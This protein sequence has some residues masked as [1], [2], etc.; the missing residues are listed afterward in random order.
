MLVEKLFS[1]IKSI[2]I[3]ATAAKAFQYLY[4]RIKFNFTPLKLKLKKKFVRGDLIVAHG[5]HKFIYYDNGDISERLYHSFWKKYYEEELNKVQNYIRKGDTVIDVGG[6][7]GFYTLLLSELVGV[8]GKVFTFE[9]FSENFKK[10]NRTISINNLNNVD[11]FNVGLGEEERKAILY[12]DSHQTGM[13]T[14]VYKISS[15]AITEEIKLT[16]LDKFFEKIKKKISFIKIDTEGYEPQVLLGGKRIL[17]KDK[18]VI[19]IELGG[20]YFES[21]LFALKILKELNY[22]CDAFNINLKEIPAGTNFICKPNN[23]IE[24]NKHPV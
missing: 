9:P 21:S 7:L 23:L 20:E 17:L 14:I 8:N 4:N 19:C 3:Q 1:N 6:N 16:T 10:L 24:R 13:S 5:K 12:Y 2:G 18:P 11:S 22:D 15:D